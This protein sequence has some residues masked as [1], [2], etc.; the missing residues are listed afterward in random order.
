MAKFTLKFIDLPVLTHIYG[1][2]N[3]G[4]DERSRDRDADR[5]QPSVGEGRGT[6]WEPD[7]HTVPCKQLQWEAAA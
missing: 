7:M 5:E 2:R 6:D 3:S 1:S 4:T